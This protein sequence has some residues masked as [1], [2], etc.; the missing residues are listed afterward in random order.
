MRKHAHMNPPTHTLPHTQ[1]GLRRKAT[2]HQTAHLTDAWLTWIPLWLPGSVCQSRCVYVCACFVLEDCLWLCASL[3]CV[4]VGVLFCRK[5]WDLRFLL[6]DALFS[7]WKITVCVCLCL[8]HEWYC[9]HIMCMHSCMNV[10]PPFPSTPCLQ[11]S[12]IPFNHL[13]ILTHWIFLVQIFKL[14]WKKYMCSTSEIKVT[15]KKG[16]EDYLHQWC[17]PK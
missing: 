6:W 11:F 1:R 16:S 9:V 13:P 2:D 10:Y 15:H 4:C 14:S 7:W 5:L 3:T 17:Q 12:F 8:V